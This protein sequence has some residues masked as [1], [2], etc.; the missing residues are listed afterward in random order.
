MKIVNKT[1]QGGRFYK[2]VSRTFK[3]LIFSIE[4]YSNMH[5]L[6]V[7]S[8]LMLITSIFVFFKFIFEGQVFIFADIGG[9][10]EHVYY[11]FF[12]SLCRK[13]QEGDMSLWDF[14]YGT[15]AN[16]LTR[17]ADV[18]NIF[19]YFTFL[20]GIGGIKYG[21]VFVH[22]IKILVSGYLCYMYLNYFHYRSITKVLVSYMFAFNG[23]TLLWGQ[24]Y[25]LGNACLYIILT[26][27][28]I[29]MS[30]K[31]PKGYIFTALSTFVVMFTSYYLAYM[32]LLFSAV[33]V[34][35]RFAYLYP[36]KQIKIVFIKGVGLLTGVLVGTCMSA[37]VFLPSVM[38]VTQTSARLSDVADILNKIGEYLGTYY[39]RK[40]ILSI[41]SRIFSNNLMGTYDFVGPSNYYEL[42]QW[43]F[44]SF[45]IFIGFIFIF[46]LILNKKECIKRRLIKML[47]M[48]FVIIA[49]FHPFISFVFNGFVAPF[50]RYT[51]VFMPILALC[52][53]SVLDKMFYDK[54]VNAKYQ[55]AVSG[56]LSLTLLS[57]TLFKIN[58]PSRM[59]QFL[60]YVYILMNVLFLTLLLLIQT[61]KKK[62]IIKSC[63]VICTALLFVANVTIESYVT[64]NKR[65]VISQVKSNIY[66]TSGNDMVKKILLE[67]EKSDPS[68]FR[69]E[70]TFQ[71]IAFLN[72][73]LLQGYYGIS[74]YNSVINKNIIE[75][76][77][78]IC[79]D[80]KV[81]EVEGYY[82]FRQ[83]MK[84]VDVVSLLGVKYILTHEHI[85]DVPEYEYQKTVGDIHIYRNTETEGIAKFF[86]K[87][88]S[89]EQFQDLEEQ[90]KESRIK[91]TLILD[92]LKQEVSKET[93]DI[94]TVLL[95]RP[96]NSSFIE[97]QVEAKQDGWVFFAIPFEKGWTAY[98]DG[99]ETELLQADIAYSAIE[100]TEG[101]HTITLRYN[102]PYLKEGI[103]ISGVG[104]A[105]FIVWCGT[106]LCTEKHRRHRKK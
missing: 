65:I 27:C 17:Q 92:G 76:K 53:S 79:P 60:G 61:E 12:V 37:I 85:T 83:I 19:T 89:G 68:F 21:L 67:L 91:D 40:V 101:T 28:A 105:V 94:S 45:T 51:Y 59:A 32:V 57:A 48:L 52:Y 30:F 86:A 16:V 82:D 80:F 2:R 74:A 44:S 31:S 104:L 9:D 84:D 15:G 81:T 18:A 35:V 98:I 62:L 5:P 41:V 49:A 13:I 47:C 64:N 50:F 10:T 24:H 88:M 100:V 71:D 103:T 55:I 34:V 1:K 26:L 33:Y 58:T 23:F 7:L 99:V 14:T 77:N 90:S 6:V 56:L 20:F 73:S 8:V 97:G 66:Q 3:S 69:V 70:K 39:D 29:E 11:P 46:E 38:I 72:D 106:I 42:P 25:F 96:S 54:L 87:A 102:T 75:F 93:T 95:D 63:C 36:F 43:F 4:K 22:I 78:Q